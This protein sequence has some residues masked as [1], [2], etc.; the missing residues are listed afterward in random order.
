MIYQQ[1]IG[2]QCL[3]YKANE[4]REEKLELLKDFEITLTEREMESFMK[5]TS[6]REIE[7]FVR[8]IIRNRLG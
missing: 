5:L 2:A 6:P 3:L 7:K 4:F 8:N 1:T